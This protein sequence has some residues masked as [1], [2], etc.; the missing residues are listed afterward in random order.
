M[1]AIVEL[2]PVPASK[3]MVMR[4]V[5][6]SIAPPI[7]RNI[8]VREVLTI[9]SSL[10]RRIHASIESARDHVIQTNMKA[11]DSKDLDKMLSSVKTHAV[12]PV[13]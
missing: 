1:V 13:S 10:W 8:Y 9:W 5:V 3:D 4:A 7:I 11:I 12:A 6:D 2:D